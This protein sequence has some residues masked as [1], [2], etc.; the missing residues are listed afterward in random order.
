MSTIMAAVVVLII[1]IAVCHWCS[2]E[3]IRAGKST[4]APPGFK[5][6]PIN[7]TLY[8]D[9]KCSGPETRDADLS[10]QIDNGV[11]TEHGFANVKELERF[12]RQKVTASTPYLAVA[13][14]GGTALLFD[15]FSTGGVGVH[16]NPSTHGLRILSLVGRVMCTMA[17][18]QF[19]QR[20]A[21][22]FLARKVA[23]Q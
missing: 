17:G 20:G 4:V 21:Q 2:E 11:G 5:L 1:I 3:R 18:P 22:I 10:L 9:L 15:G 23:P 6:I 16:V 7:A 13:V 14:P 12:L 8:G 19:A